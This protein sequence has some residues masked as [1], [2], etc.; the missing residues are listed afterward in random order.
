GAYLL[1][2]G[3]FMPWELGEVL[4]RQTIAEGLRRLAPQRL[5]ADAIKP[6]PRSAHARVAVLEASLYMRNQLLRDTDWASMAHSV[7]VRVPLVDRILLRRVAEAAA[8][9]RHAWA[10]IPKAALA[11]SPR[12]ALPDRILDRPKTGFTT[13]IAQWLQTRGMSVPA[14]PVPKV[15]RSAHWSRQWAERLAM[16]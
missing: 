15:P 16:V 10:G 14:A 8:M 3:L 4:S 12:Q 11:L 2:R 6:H 5:I 13:P 1:R 7:E 9:T